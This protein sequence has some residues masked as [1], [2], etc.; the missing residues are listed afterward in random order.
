MKIILIL[1][2]LIPSLAHAA[3]CVNKIAKS[4]FIKRVAQV[5]NAGLLTC[6]DLPSEQCFC[7]DGKSDYRKWKLGFR[8]IDITKTQDCNNATDCQDTV[9]EQGFPCPNEKVTFDDKTNWPALD[10]AA[11]SRPATG[12]FLWC[13]KQIIVVDAAG[14]AIADAADAQ[15][16]IDN[17]TRATKSAERE[18]GAAACVTAVN[19]GGVLTNPEIQNCLNVLVKEQFEQLIAPGDL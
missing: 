6:K 14:A 12:F 16:V 8:A 15:L 11:E 19:G 18:T 10:F 5:P 13:E 4:E 1:I 3:D 2:F 9:D 7:L 17:A